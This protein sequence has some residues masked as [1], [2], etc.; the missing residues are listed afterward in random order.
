MQGRSRRIVLLAAAAV[1]VWYVVVLFGWAVR[2][3]HDSVPI[4]IDFDAKA[5]HL[6]SAD[7]TC[8]TLFAGSAHDGPLPVLRVLTKNTP[9]PNF[10]QF[11]YQRDVCTA[12]Q[13]DARIV[14]ALDTLGMLVTVGGLTSLVVRRPREPAGSHRDP[15]PN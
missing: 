1:V 3:L 10:Q 7:V 9:A 5:P 14:F 8:N 12:T 15:A 4:G 2:P 11:A 13:R 6:I